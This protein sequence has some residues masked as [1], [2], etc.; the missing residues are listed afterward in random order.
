M[1]RTPASC[2]SSGRA[3][4][5]SRSRL[6]NGRLASGRY[7]G[8]LA[9]VVITLGFSQA[10]CVLRG[11]QPQAKAI[12]VAPAPAVETPPPPPAAK[13]SVPQTT[14]ELPPPQPVNLEGLTQAPPAEETPAAPTN[15]TRRGGKTGAPAPKPEPAAT[16]QQ[17]PPAPATP[18]PA[19]PAES[20]R[21]P[22]QE[23]VAPEEQR[24]LQDLWNA[25]QHEIQQR[26]EQIQ[27]RQLN[28][29]E[30]AIVN[31]IQSFLKQAGAAAG[32]G[33]WRGASELAERGLALARDLS[34]GK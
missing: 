14:V 20:D 32:R 15:A 24:R 13:L 33:D 30:R 7:D 8:I 27:S 31:R 17:G 34:G 2:P 5:P 26:L 3:T 12:P 10:G 19:A 1:K 23:I 29:T 6:S 22:L 18:T 4:A 9:I 16:A 21:P 28:H 25:D 11:K